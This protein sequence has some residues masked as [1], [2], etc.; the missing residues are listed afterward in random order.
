MIRGRGLLRGA[1]ACSG[2][3]FLLGTGCRSQEAP[4]GA[5]RA[6]TGAGARV[7]DSSMPR[8]TDV[9][10]ATGIDFRHTTGAAG[11]KYMPETMG[12]GCAFIDYDNDGRQ[13]I[14]L[15]NGQ[16]WPD[17]EAF[18]RSGGRKPA[19]RSD[20][21]R[22][23]AGRP[24]TMILYRNDPAGRFVDVTEAVGL[25]KPLY[26]MGVAV[27]D[28]DND[29]YDDMAVTALGGV[30][31]FHNRS[32]RRFVEADILRGSSAAS[33]AAP[34]TNPDGGWPTGA[35]WLDYDRDGRLDL[36]VCHYVRWTPETDVYWSLDGVHKSYTTPE[37][38]QGESCRLY[39]NMENG[40]L[41]DVS[42]AAGIYSARSKALGVAVCDYDSDGWPDILVSNDT[43]PN[44]VFHNQ[45]DGTFHDV[46][47]ELGMA[48]A[49]SGKPKAG[50]GIATGDDRNDGSESV[51]VTNFAGEQISLYRK[52]STGQYLDE[53]AAAGVGLPSQRYLGFGAFFFDA[54]LDGWLDIFVSNGHVM[55]D[56]ERRNTGVT[57]AEP[58][59][60][61]LNDR[62]GR[63]REIAQSVGPELA[64]PRVGRGAAYGD[65]DND[66]D[67]DILLTTNGGPARLLRN[68]AGNSHGWLKLQLEGGPS[69]R[70]AYGARVRVWTGGRVMSRTVSSGSSY[71]SASDR[72][73]TF[74]L[75]EVRGADRIEI[76][77]PSGAVQSLGPV[78]GN[79]WLRITEGRS[80]SVAVAR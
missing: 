43:E 8:F 63:Y 26:G 55:D 20:Q 57:Y 29:G 49:E 5:P 16:P 30:R 38:Y 37:K 65:F 51:L 71:L 77:W 41:V 66:G 64:A 58:A 34:A 61:F 12:S 62:Q 47:T 36:F 11:R 67:L 32:G 53:A 68:D 35:A 40:R 75:G 56:I 14:L 22:S 44:M 33:D 13:D 45:G 7:P 60:L 15:I 9:T 70:N 76:R 18:T 3:L 28:W 31:L 27:G 6:A 4:A 74:G 59:L 10:A 48:V 78:E 24:S 80:G 23:G 25:D 17:V 72:R 39:R 46:A 79:R 42:R 21:R 2:L 73:L 69:N 19:A 52:D 50:M 1:A 54:D